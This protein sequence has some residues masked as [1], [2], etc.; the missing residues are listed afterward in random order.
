MYQP[1]LS[2]KRVCIVFLILWAGL[3]LLSFKLVY[4]QFLTDHDLPSIAARQ[5]NVVQQLSPHRG[6][7]YDRNLRPLAMTLEVDSIYAN[8]AQIGQKEKTAQLLSNVL[9]LNRQELSK[10]LHRKGY[11]V[12]LKRWATQEEAEKVKVLGI[13]GVGIVKEGRR[14][15]PNKQLAA[16][17]IGIAGMDGIGLEGIEKNCDSYLRGSPGWLWIQRDAKGRRIAA[18]SFDF[19]PPLHGYDVVLTIDEGLQFI[20]EKALEEALAKIR[21]KGAMVVVMDP[22]NGDILALA[23]RPTFDPNRFQ[24][25]E[26]DVRRNRTLTDFFEPGSVFKIV[27]A[28]A[29][30]QEKKVK[31]DQKFYCEK[32]SWKVA[33]HILHDHRPH[34]WLT[35]QQVIEKSSN[36]GTVKVAMLVGGQ[37][38]YRYIKAFGFGVPTQIELPGEVSGIVKPTSQWS[39]TS[40]TAIPMGQEVATTTLQL[41]T[42]FSV[43]ANGGQRVQPRIVREVR[44]SFQEPIKSVESKLGERVLS[45]EVVQTMK[46]ILVGVVEQGTGTLAKVKGYQVAGKTGTAQKVEPDGTYSHSKFVA[47]FIGFAPA[48]NPAL[49]ICV[50][51]DEPRPY[52][53]GGV[54]SAPIFKQIAAQSLK[55]LGVPSEKGEIGSKIKL[56]KQE[57]SSAN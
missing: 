11:F 19:I 44:D 25:A 21:S 27:T 53:Y 43:I 35:F 29:A 33:G 41:A 32:G 45:P 34:G 9:N 17:V 15:Y 56:A 4:L 54:V 31:L 39:K 42:A 51:V 47:S 26:P 52:Y 16:H 28:S 49:T 3:I 37:N 36:I 55:Y 38:L 14:F 20:V 13:E 48:K 40:I 2:T 22:R 50:I 12:W 18:R 46:K 8:P 23:N 1:Q 24:K 57:K 5:K 10:R 6:T 7:I 30:L